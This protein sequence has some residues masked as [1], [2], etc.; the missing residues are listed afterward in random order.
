MLKK[1]RSVSAKVNAI[2]IALATLLVVT[3]ISL[4]IYLNNIQETL[5]NLNQ[6]SIP[7]IVNAG[8]IHNKVNSL[9]SL[10][11]EFV[12]SNNEVSKRIAK[13]KITSRLEELIELDSGTHDSGIVINS[14]IGELDALDRLLKE[15]T[16]IHEQIIDTSYEVQSFSSKIYQSMTKIPHNLVTDDVRGSWILKISQIIFKSTFQGSAYSVQD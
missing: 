1:Y 3:C 8:H 4:F 14:I 16:K 2:L 15:K 5:V 10:T 7:A 11:Q 6:E 9:T 12:H 13:N